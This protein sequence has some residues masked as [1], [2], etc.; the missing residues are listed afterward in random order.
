MSFEAIWKPVDKPF[1]ILFGLRCTLP[2]SRASLRVSD[3]FPS[4]TKI[5]RFLHQ[6]LGI[7]SIVGSLLLLRFGRA[8][9]TTTETGSISPI[10]CRM[11]FCNELIGYNRQGLTIRVKIQTQSLG[12]DA[13]VV[14]GEYPPRWGV[15]A[16]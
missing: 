3:E 1:R 15:L 16:L 14:A 9:M 2:L 10:H 13:H 4:T 12:V 8:V 7:E 11:L 6:P 5:S